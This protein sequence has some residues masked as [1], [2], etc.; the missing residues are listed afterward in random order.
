MDYVNN[1][2]YLY[3]NYYFIRSFILF[4]ITFVRIIIRS[5]VKVY[6]EVILINKGTKKV[7]SK[8]EPDHDRVAT[9]TT[10]IPLC[11]Q[12]AFLGT[13]VKRPISLKDLENITHT[14]SYPFVLRRFVSLTNEDSFKSYTTNASTHRK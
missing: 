8:R 5:F 7:T 4:I 6:F 10:W 12:G 3:F 11:V 1:N 9:M 2:F 14:F 13:D